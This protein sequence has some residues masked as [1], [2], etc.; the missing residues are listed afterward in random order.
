MLVLTSGV[1]GMLQG[2][3]DNHLRGMLTHRLA[4]EARRQELQA[5][6]AALAAAQE[7][8]QVRRQAHM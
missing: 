7:A 8:F 6:L 1:R 3:V 4:L 5:A 2:T